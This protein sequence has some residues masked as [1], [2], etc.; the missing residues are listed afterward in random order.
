[1][2]WQFGIHLCQSICVVLET[3][4][5][6]PVGDQEDNVEIVSFCVQKIEV[7]K[8]ILFV[9][10]VSQNPSKL[11]NIKHQSYA[12]ACASFI[13]QIKR[14]SDE[15]FFDINTFS[16]LGHMLFYVLECFFTL[17]SHR[18]SVIIGHQLFPQKSL[19]HQS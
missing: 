3:A 14:I 6:G 4:N 10:Y 1:M 5:F 11:D 15:N 2:F 9:F 13:R 19:P 7:L 8:S 12:N 18:P 16:L 17:P